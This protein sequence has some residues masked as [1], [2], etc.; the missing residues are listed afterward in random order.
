[1][2]Q[3]KKKSPNLHTLEKLYFKKEEGKRGKEKNLVLKVFS[4]SEEYK[5]LIYWTE[6]EEMMG[7]SW[8]FE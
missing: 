6:I 2:I 4:H 7:L 8:P 5:V 1:M 3:F